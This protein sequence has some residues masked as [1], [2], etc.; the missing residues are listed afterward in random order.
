MTP[1]HAT[2]TRDQHIAD[3]R[4]SIQR[5]IPHLSYAAGHIADDNPEYAA[6]LLATADEMTEL[7]NRTTPK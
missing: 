3:L 5:A 2:D 4:A 6:R 7:L 1:D